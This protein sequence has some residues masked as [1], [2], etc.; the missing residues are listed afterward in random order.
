MKIDFFIK[1]LEGEG[2]GAE[3]VLATVSDELSKLG[4]AVTVFTSDPSGFV[5]FYEMSA[6]VELKGLGFSN[7]VSRTGVKT[8]V[9]TVQ[10]MRKIYKTRR[11]DVVIGFMHSMYVPLSVALLGKNIP[12]I[13]SEH[14]ALTHYQTRPLQGRLASWAQ[15]RASLMTVPAPS[16]AEGRP[17]NIQAKIIVLPNPV[18]LSAYAASA[19][20][21]PAKDPEIVLNVGRLMEQKNQL[22]LIRSFANVAPQFPNWILRIVGEGEMRP[23]MEALAQELGVADKVQIPGVVRGMAKEY[24]AASF[25]ALPSHYEAMPLTVME[26]LASGR[27]VLGFEHCAG[28]TNLIETGTNGILLGATDTRVESFAGGLADMMGKVD[29]RTQMSRAAPASMERFGTPTIMRD[30]E[31][32]LEQATTGG[33]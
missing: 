18:D 23:A 25:L 22:E 15:S 7:A 19:Q 14:I 6:D 28:L 5:P 33:T 12:F 26:A 9:G 31:R 10:T 27:C 16:I 32:L 29:R 11:P 30:W 4:H 13:A 3:R 2:G 17:T 8:F 21:R 20:V 24:E 1:S